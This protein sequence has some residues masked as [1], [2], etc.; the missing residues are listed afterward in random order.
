MRENEELFIRRMQEL[1]ATLRQQTEFYL[2]LGDTYEECHGCVEFLKDVIENKDGYRLFWPGGQPIRRRRASISS[3]PD[4][5][6]G[7]M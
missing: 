3:P 6:I 7:N 5:G 2:A 1:V 4:T